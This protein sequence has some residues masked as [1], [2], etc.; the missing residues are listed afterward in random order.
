MS[1]CALEGEVG[2]MFKT[3]RFVPSFRRG[4]PLQVERPD[5]FVNRRCRRIAPDDTFE[6]DLRL[7]NI[8]SWARSDDEAVLFKRF[9]TSYEWT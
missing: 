9:A 2:S 5:E 4:C 8:L 6:G 3:N 1:P 7:L